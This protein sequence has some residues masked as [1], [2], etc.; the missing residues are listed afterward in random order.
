MILKNSSFRRNLVYQVSYEILIILLPLILSPY[1]SRVLKPEGL[2]IYSYTHSIANYFVLFSMLGI[3]TYG[4]RVIAQVR[5]DKDKLNQTFSNLLGIHILIS[6]MCILIYGIYLVNTCEYKIYFVIQMLF[7][8]SALWDISWFYFGIEEFKLSVLRNIFTKV[9]AVILIFVFV[10]ESE[11]L[12]IYCLIMSGSVLISQL[13][14][15]LPLSK[16]ISLVK[17][18]WKIGWTYIKPM[19]ILFLPTI[20]VSLYRY[21]D[22]IMLGILSNRTAVGYYSNSDQLMSVPAAIISAFGTVMLPKMSN[23]VFKGNTESSNKYMNISMQYFMCLSIGM[24]F[25]LAGT[26]RVFAPL[27]WGENFAGCSKLI[28][29]LSLAIPFI[30]FANVLRTQYLIPNSKDKTY[31]LSVISG[32]ITNLVINW[33]LIPSFGAMGAVVGTIVAEFTVCLVQSVA[34]LTILPIL[35]YIRR[36]IPYLIYGAIMFV[37]VYLLGEKLEGGIVTLLIQII[38]GTIIYLIFCLVH[39]VKTKDEVICDCLKKLKD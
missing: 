31:T 24:M 32:A 11:D 15:W 10:K 23:L 29:G 13:L 1:V 34:A 17:C 4:N 35:F 36:T 19:L 25:G 27:F 28:M 14:L 8:V 16:Y 20:A 2:G 22:K 37:I 26:A 38:T 6:L 30:T 33:L 9:L 3:K 12:W 21:M 18:N 7:V 5:D 39:L